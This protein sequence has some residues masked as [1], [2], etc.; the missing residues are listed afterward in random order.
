D[1]SAPRKIYVAVKILS[2]HGTA[3]IVGRFCAKYEA[4]RRIESANPH[5]PDFPRCLTISHCFI[6]QSS[7]GGH[8]CF[9]IDVSG[10]DM[11]PF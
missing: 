5:H 6:T 4:F 11:G 2:R 9:A 10:S 3:C 8:I 1:T 7:V